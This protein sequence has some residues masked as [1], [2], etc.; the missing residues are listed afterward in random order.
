VSFDPKIG[1]QGG[2]NPFMGGVGLG[3][4]DQMSTEK[5]QKVVAKVVQGVMTK[6]HVSAD[7]KVTQALAN[8]LA[9]QMGLSA[10]KLMSPADLALLLKTVQSKTEQSM[11]ALSKNDIERIQKDQKDQAEVRLKNLQDQIEKANKAAKS[12]LFGQIFGWIAAAFMAI[13]GAIMIATGVGAAAGAALLVG[14]IAMMTAMALST[15]G[16]DGTSPMT[17]M[18]DGIAKG[19]VS[20]GMDPKAAQGLATGLIA[21]VFIAASA[22]AFIFAGPAG[23]IA[24]LG[25]LLPLLVT[26]D[27]LVKMGMD[28]HEAEKLSL[29]LTIGMAVA[30]IAVTAG[31]ALASAAGKIASNLATLT[32]RI[33]EKAI[34]NLLSFAEKAAKASESATKFLGP[35]TDITERVSTNLALR[36]GLAFK[37][38]QDT[39]NTVGRVGS[40]VAQFGQGLATVGTG[41]AQGVGVEFTKQ[42][43]DAEAEEKLL[44]AFM[45][46]LSDK[47]QSE[48][49]RLEEMIRKLMNFD[50]VVSMMQG[51]F[52]AAQF[53]ERHS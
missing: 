51:A 19:L 18:I 53:V 52:E 40:F 9:L 5:V 6:S 29:G 49:E 3:G 2:Q 15:P 36:I 43:R 30:A 35:M 26:P 28:R 7:T 4:D 20:L 16:K 38:S 23:G 17:K 25:S 13:A 1:G 44:K 11:I 39:L 34:Q 24:V 41:V 42:L 21:A 14:G 10:A 8:S 37:I 46:N 48:K 12:G 45:L 33:G 27:N 47:F 22:P 50:P 31:P 32:E